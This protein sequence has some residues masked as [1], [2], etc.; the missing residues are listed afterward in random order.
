MRLNRHTLWIALLAALPASGR[1]QT[2]A[3]PA[4]QAELLRAVVEAPALTAASRR[5]EAARERVESSGRLRDPEFEGMTSRMNGP[6]G[7]RGTMYELTL[8]QPLPRRG[9][10]SADRDRA[11]AGVAMAEADYAL[12]AGE[13]AADIAM[14]LAEAE[15]AEARIR[16]LQT[17]LERLDAVLRSVEV[18]LAAGATGRIADR[19]TVLTRIASMQLML[20]E[21]RKMAADALSDAR[22]RLGLDPDAPLPAYAAPAVA[23][24]QAADAAAL[25]LASARSD[26]AAAMARMARASANPMTAVGIRLERERGGMGNEDTIGLAFMSEIPWRG[27]RYA[28]SDIRAADAERA[29]APSDATSARFRIASA[30][31]RVER[32]ERLADAAR[33]LSAETLGR[34]DAEYDSMIRSAGVAG[35]GES[36]VL[37]TVELLE[38]A[39]ETELQVIQADLAARIARAELWRHLPADRFPLPNH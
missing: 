2:A 27:R 33:R 31:S 36:T 32:A 38:K 11:H 4:A 39:T 12:M 1:A 6:M 24:I 34:L 15:S 18:R 16:L 8:R 37:Q 22:G 10:R 25:R 9:E 17:Q 14:A 21:E 13:M 30:I 20:E 7:E 3:P 19:L 28:R 5:A 35:P 26:E 29:A 23:D